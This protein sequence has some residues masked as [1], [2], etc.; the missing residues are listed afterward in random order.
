MGT[1]TKC[2]CDECPC[3][4][5]EDLPTVTISGYTGQGWT[6]DCCYQQQF[7][8]NSTPAWSK[9][10]TE[11]IYSASVYETC[12]TEHWRVNPSLYRGYEINPST[13][14]DIPDQYCCPSNLKIA[15]TTST[16]I[17]ENSGFMALWRRIKHIIVRVSQEL[18][19]CTGV[20]GQESG[21]K[22]VIRSRIVY[23][24]ATTFYENNRASF[25]QEVEMNV[26]T[27]FEPDPDYVITSNP[28][29]PI[30]CDDVPASPPEGGVGG[31]GC[32]S[33]GEFYFDR[34][35]YYDTMPTGNIVFGNGDVPGCNASTCDYS[36]YNYG[37][38]VCIYSPSQYVRTAFCT[39]QEPCYC[40]ADIVEYDNTTTEPD[41]SCDS[42]IL[43]YD[44]C[45]GCEGQPFWVC[46][47]DICQNVEDE[48]P[49]SGYS[50]RALG[51]DTDAGLN[52]AYCDFDGTGST[53]IRSFLGFVACGANK[54]ILG[55]GAIDPPYQ[56][57]YDPCQ[58][59]D[60]DS[61]CCEFIDDCPCCVEEVCADKYGNTWF[62]TVVTHTRTQTCSGWN[63]KSICTSAPSWTINLA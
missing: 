36:P 1:L 10:C 48:C 52:E 47:T 3:L 24:Y 17:W 55:V 14:D 56:K 7:N 8:P 42:D 25:D 60:C 21:C 35:R 46:T 41:A 22:I 51:F 18:A 37:N 31:D 50:Y 61:V 27:C 13:C 12:I 58:V 44:G 39:F 32:L 5:V 38:Q 9:S 15:T 53:G 43:I 57:T 40:W 45:T 26:E 33:T 63:P 29:T 20:E 34:V 16:W 11:D 30:T 6:G 23:E 19:N 54:S 4:P 28:F 49:D 62:S 2:C 59:G